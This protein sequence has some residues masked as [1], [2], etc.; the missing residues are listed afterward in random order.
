MGAGASAAQAADSVFSEADA[1]Q[2]GSVSLKDLEEVLTKREDRVAWPSDRIHE[3]FKKHDGDGDGLLTRE[4]YTTAFGTIT[5]G[6]APGTE[7]APA[8]EPACDSGS[9]PSIAKSVS[10]PSM[11]ERIAAPVF[12]PFRWDEAA[13][14]VR[15]L[16]SG[17]GAKLALP[18][19][20]ELSAA[21]LDMPKLTTIEITGGTFEL[22]SNHKAI[23]EK[24]GYSEAFR[25]L[26]RTE[27]QRRLAQLASLDAMEKQAMA[28]A[29]CGCCNDEHRARVASTIGA[30][31]MGDVSSLILDEALNV[32]VPPAL[33]QIGKLAE[34]RILD[35]TRNQLGAVPEY[36]GGLTSLQ[37]L[38]LYDCGLT[39]LPAALGKL[40]KL[41]K[42]ELGDNRLARLPD[43]F[44]ELKALRELGVFH[45]QMTVL[46]PWVAQLP[47]LFI[48]NADSNPWQSPPAS[49]VGSVSSDDGKDLAPL[50]RYYEAIEKHGASTSHRAKMV[51]MGT[52][53]A[54]KSSTLR[55]MKY[56]EPRPFAE[57]ERTVQLDIWTLTLGEVPVL[58]DALDG[59][60]DKRIVLS[61][62]DFAGQPEY[63]AG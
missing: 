17:D 19:M 22:I 48:L 39:E 29:V 59:V 42:L 23:F 13:E 54:G 12:Y 60:E 20:A 4:E 52:G 9:A 51:L 33:E 2:K 7:A 61:A 6:S 10:A 40:R 35:L 15:E 37:Q 49:V 26:L 11:A 47:H 21:L 45:N 36:L 27:K 55:G 8:S 63:A 25:E 50:R 28:D 53:K 14:S 57:D 41:Q 62:W 1:S 44:A 16:E 31:L 46:P 24:E 34:L 30:I 5:S 18:K 43:S 58:S 38:L 56:S 32:E 3:A